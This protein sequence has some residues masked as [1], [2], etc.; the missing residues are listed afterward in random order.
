MQGKLLRRREEVRSFLDGV[1]MDIVE[2]LEH[3]I[4]KVPLTDKEIQESFQLGI[5][6]T[7]VDEEE[8]GWT[9]R[10][11]G[12]P[13]KRAHAIGDMGETAVQKW[14]IEAKVPFRP[15]PKLVKNLGDIEQDIRVGNLRV[16]VKTAESELEAAFKY[17][18]FLYP[19]KNRPGE[20]R[21]VLDYPDYLV[22]AVVSTKQ[23]IVWLVGFVSRADLESAPVRE[24]VEKPAHMIPHSKY[25]DCDDFLAILRP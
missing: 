13:S 11:K 19:A 6:R 23:K 14:L 12:M 1:G 25:R 10:H 15:A 4:V 16:G 24:I 18:L 3:R 5:D 22:Q 2:H 20:S 8:L 7:K 17:G 9:Y 21:R